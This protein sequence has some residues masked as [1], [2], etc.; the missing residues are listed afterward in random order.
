MHPFQ[1]DFLPGNAVNGECGSH[2]KCLSRFEELGTRQEAY[3]YF[4][5]NR[6]LISSVPVENVSHWVSAG[7]CL[8]AHYGSVIRPPED[9]CVL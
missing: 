3:F 5:G 2:C 7:F 8:T 9:F 4:G 1:V 6:L